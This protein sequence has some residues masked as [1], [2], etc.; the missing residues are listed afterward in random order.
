MMAI[1]ARFAD[2][3]NDL[4]P[5]DDMNFLYKL[6]L[7]NKLKSFLSYDRLKELEKLPLFFQLAQS[8][9]SHLVEQVCF[10]FIRSAQ[11]LSDTVLLF[12][13]L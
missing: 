6:N 13:D 3:K 2:F 12:F 1:E 7:D 4:Q 9:F 5:P 8:H 11:H 10:S